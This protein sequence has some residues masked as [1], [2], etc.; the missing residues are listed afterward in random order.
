MITGSE[1]LAVNKI[2]VCGNEEQEGDDHE[3]EERKRSLRFVSP[4]KT[5][6]LLTRMHSLF[7]LFT[8]ILSYYFCSNAK[9]IISDHIR[10][11]CIE[12]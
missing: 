4:R 3:A 2:V 1:I 6:L 11:I 12:L 7:C 5:T 10:F 9:I 8:I